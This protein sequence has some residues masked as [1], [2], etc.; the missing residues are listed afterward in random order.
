MSTTRP[1][2]LSPRPQKP[3]LL[4]DVDGVITLLGPA[5]DSTFET[6]AAGYPMRLDNQIG[7]RV[8]RLSGHFHIVFC[9]SW[10]AE[11]SRSVA[12]LLGLPENLPFIPFKRDLD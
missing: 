3:L 12:P 9:T 4:L 11:A 8:R 5:S 10:T 7:S 6:S 2:D 1:I